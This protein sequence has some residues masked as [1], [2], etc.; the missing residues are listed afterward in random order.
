MA[1]VFSASAGRWDLP[2]RG[3]VAA[4]S[5]C[6][7]STALCFQVILWVMC[8]FLSRCLRVLC[9]LPQVVLDRVKN[10]EKLPGVSEILLPSERGNR[11]AQHHIDSG[12]LP[13]ETNL[14]QNLKVM[15]SKAD[16]PAGSASSNGAG[17]SQHAAA[18]AGGYKLETM[19]LHPAPGSVV[20][21]FDA[22]GPPLYQTA[23]FGQP[24]ATEC[25]PFDYTRSGNPTRTMLE[26]Q[27]G[28]V[29]GLLGL[30]RRPFCPICTAVMCLCSVVCW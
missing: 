29:G 9:L 20:D 28:L 18:G 17:G 14:Y 2:L 26:E 7:L 30:C 5:T 12:M 16:A 1:P 24:G 13:I 11:V 15:A 27:V 3:A 19:L 22:S 21:P 8:R 23:T 10:A 6:P 25:G 4:A